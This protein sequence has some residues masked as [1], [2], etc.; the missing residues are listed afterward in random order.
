MALRLRERSY[1]SRSG[2][3]QT[4]HVPLIPPRGYQLIIE[5]SPNYK[6]SNIYS[7]IYSI[8]PWHIWGHFFYS[9]WSVHISDDAVERVGIRRGGGCEVFIWAILKHSK[10]GIRMGK[11][12]ETIKERQIFFDI[13]IRD[14]TEYILH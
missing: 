12:S 5:R 7:Y 13:N 10:H 1:I 3:K 11:V 8:F 6:R 2:P 4:G 9:L 14:T